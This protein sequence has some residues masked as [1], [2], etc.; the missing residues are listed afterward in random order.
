MMVR[1]YIKEFQRM[2]SELHIRDRSQ[3]RGYC[4][5]G[6]DGAKGFEDAL[7]AD[8][9]AIRCAPIHPPELHLQVPVVLWIQLRVQWRVRLSAA[10]ADLAV[11]HSQAAGGRPPQAARGVHEIEEIPVKRPRVPPARSRHVPGREVL[12]R[13]RS[14]PPS[15]RAGRDRV[16]GDDEKVLGHSGAAPEEAEAASRRGTQKDPLS[17]HHLRGDAEAK[18][19]AQDP[20]AD[21]EEGRPRGKGVDGRGGRSQ[22]AALVHKDVPNLQRPR[23]ASPPGRWGGGRDS[24]YLQ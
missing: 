23:L 2:L 19:S 8:V 13:C 15:P 1:L 17:S 10:G 12:Q 7:G 20:R 18:K 11:I 22:N 4:Q 21:V 6:Q 16:L 9:P 14:V 5:E 24:S 3:P